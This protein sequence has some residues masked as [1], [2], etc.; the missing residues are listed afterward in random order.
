MLCE[1]N[2]FTGELK[3]GVRAEDADHG[4]ALGIKFARAASKFERRQRRFH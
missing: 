1:D 2:G 4:D 3:P